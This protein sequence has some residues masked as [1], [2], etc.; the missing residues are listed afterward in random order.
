MPPLIGNMNPFGDPS[1]YQGFHSPHYTDSHRALGRMVREVVE[2]D[3]IPNVHEWD[4][5]GVIPAEFRQ[6]AYLTGMAV[7]ACGHPLPLEYGPPLP[8]FLKGVKLD[9]FHAIVVFQ[10]VCRSGS[11]GVGW[12]L[13]GGLCIGLP[14]I[15]A[16]GSPELKQRIAPSVLSG[17]KVVC[18]A[19]T[20]P[21]AGSD[22]GRIQTTAVKSA[23]GK[24]YI[25]NGVKK[26]I[27]N[28]CFSDFM[29]VLVRTGG[30]G[31][32]G[33][34]LLVIETASPGVKTTKMKCSGVWASG[35]TLI[36]L[37]QV[38]VPIHNLIGTENKGF[39][40]IVHNF[41]YER[42]I[43]CA[44]AIASARTC[45][46]EAWIH[47]HRRKTFG[48]LLAEHQVIRFKLGDMARQIEACQAWLENIA[49][50]V[51]TM[52]PREADLKLGG[53]AAL[54][55][56]QCTKVLELCARE[57]AQ[58]FGGLSFTRGGLGEKVERLGRE[59]R[60]LAIPGGSEEIMIDLGV[61]MSNKVA[62]LGQTML[63]NPQ[64][65][66]QLAMAKRVGV[67][68]EVFG[69]GY[70]FSDPSWYLAFNTPFYS[71][72]HRRFRG[73]M[74]SLLA[75]VVGPHVA[76]W[77]EAGEIPRS[78]LIRLYDAGVGVLAAGPP[79]KDH[80]IACLQGVQVDQFHELIAI[81][82][83]SRFGSAGLVGAIW[84]GFST[85]VN[86]LRRLQ[87]ARPELIRD[88]LTGRQRVALCVTES[89]VS[90][91]G[92]NDVQSTV[93][94]SITTAP[95]I[96]HQVS[97]QKEYVSNGLG[98]DWF[99][100]AAKLDGVVSLV[101][102][103][104]RAS[105]VTVTGMKCTGSWSGGTA[106]VGFAHTPCVMIGS[107]GSAAAALDA[108]VDHERWV[109]AV[110][111][112]RFARVCYED[113][114]KHAQ[115][116]GLIDHQGIRWKF[117]EMGRQIE[118][119][120]NWLESVTYQSVCSPNHPAEL[121]SGTIGLVKLHATKTLEYCS[122]EASQTLGSMAYTR[123]GAV[124]RISREVRALALTFG[125]EEVLLDQ[126]VRKAERFA[127]AAKAHGE[128]VS[129]GKSRM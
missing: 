90:G 38:R 120:F 89:G 26:W 74:R 97:G 128:E 27:T 81:D 31:I 73:F 48:K 62:Q 16:F 68:T 122:R 96:T 121:L 84:S 51:E 42:V 24:F 59:V 108:T 124:E 5:A 13:G 91:H 19:V 40:Y 101:L 58:I 2:T 25:V 8:D 86:I 44:Q 98:A 105:G 6:K 85:C 115:A 28:G 17:D 1:W 109:I 20:E 52:H 80:K 93:I 129:L 123:G 111:A 88:V 87:P 35:T 64:V 103:D 23:C 11:I 46:E 116:R 65:G 125:S 29:T 100:V 112:I 4:E 32:K 33:L 9:I 113:A 79:Y 127:V 60:S 114:L 39:K 69:E 41:N 57:S 119:A 83:L 34:S 77:D 92:V 117:G 49:F 45:Y 50:Q 55:K 53:P 110:E 30:E 102:V 71:E 67:N 104:A 7:L 37:D 56:V 72:S 76:E 118:G 15:L 94:Q 21:N 36:T 75:D 126:G 22:V 3:L 61:R 106:R 10:E 54:L 95:G 99:I 18:L 107:P 63:N 43:I 47:A 78:V 12:G 82:E 70:P 66:R 14:P